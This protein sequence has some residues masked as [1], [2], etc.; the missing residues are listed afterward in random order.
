MKITKALSVSIRDSR[1]ISVNNYHEQ[2]NLL[3][4]FFLFFIGLQVCLYEY[5]IPSVWFILREYQYLGYN[6]LNIGIVISGE[7]D[8]VFI[9]NMNTRY[10]IFH[11]R[12]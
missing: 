3:L 12:T 10:R 1:D 2:R 11:S 8:S 7:F 6:A 4:H 5:N 9:H